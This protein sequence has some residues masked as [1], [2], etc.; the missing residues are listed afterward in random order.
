MVDAIICRAPRPFQRRRHSATDLLTR[1]SAKPSRAN[2]LRKP[3]YSNYG[4]G[5]LDTNAPPLRADRGLLLGDAEPPNA[6][7]DKNC[8]GPVRGLTDT[9]MHAFWRD[10]RAASEGAGSASRQ[11]EHRCRRQVMRT[12]SFTP[13]VF[14]AT[15]PSRMT[16]RSS[17]ADDHHALPQ[18]GADGALKSAV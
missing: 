10:D 12:P 14:A 16:R 3:H 8:V 13:V 11:R 1:R 15:S 7:S 18:G 17:D 4:G 2:P 6:N 9:A 5:R